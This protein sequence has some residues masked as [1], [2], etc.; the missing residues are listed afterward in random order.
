MTTSNPESTDDRVWSPD[1]TS[2]IVSDGNAF[3]THMNQKISAPEDFEGTLTRCMFL[4]DSYC[5]VGFQ[6]LK[7]KG[8]LVVY[9]IHSSNEPWEKVQLL[10]SDQAYHF[11]MISYTLGHSLFVISFGSSSNELVELLMDRGDFQLVRNLV[12]HSDPFWGVDLL[13]TESHVFIGVGSHLIEKYDRNDWSAPLETK[14][15]LGSPGD[16]VQ[17][18]KQLRI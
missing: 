15:V 12:N 18:K 8:C 14:I 9:R 10:S 13:V 6:S 16:A 5:V 2:W 7:H 11:G 1:Q 4:T 17:I 3:W